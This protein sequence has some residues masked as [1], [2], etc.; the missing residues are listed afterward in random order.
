MA[1]AGYVQGAADDAEGWS[2]GLSAEGF[3][4]VI[5][6]SGL[7]DIGEVDLAGLVE[8]VLKEGARKGGWKSKENCGVEVAEGLF[9]GSTDSALTVWEKKEKEFTRNI[10]VLVCNRTVSGEKSSI[11]QCDICAERTDK[12]CMNA[13]NETSQL[14]KQLCL[15]LPT[16]KLGSRA[17]RKELPR[18]KSFI[19]AHLKEDIRQRILVTCETG[20]DLAVGVALMVLCLFYKDNGEFSSRYLV[21]RRAG[22]R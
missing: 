21:R 7:N 5:G 19:Y 2:G 15:D 17:L 14:P 12:E 10:I 11:G 4:E 18:I 22:Y 9:V 13:D 20:K 1:Q 6:R 8:D 16:G 3:W